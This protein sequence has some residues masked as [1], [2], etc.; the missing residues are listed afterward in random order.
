[1]TGTR[2]PQQEDSI[3][4]MLSDS[5]LESAAELRS[6]LEQLRAAVPGE[7]PAPRADLAALLAAGAPSAAR[8]VPAGTAALPTIGTAVLPTVGE[9]LPTV[10]A[11]P[12]G[13][14]EDAADE[15]LPA[16]VTSLAE[17]RGRKRRLAIVGG[18][19]VGAMTLGAGAV[20]ASSEDFRHSVS[21]TVGVIFHP[22]GEGR[23]A[24]PV[25]A[26]PSPADLP[27]A[28]VPSHAA[29]TP[30]PSTAGT[31]P[32]TPGSAA[33]VHAEP[34]DRATPPATGRGGILPTPPHRPVTPHMP[35]LPGR[36]GGK[37]LPENPLPEPTLPSMLPSLPDH[38]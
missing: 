36:D 20:A 30:T 31:A 11:A 3:Q 13:P 7:A 26:T 34:G 2:D 8:R 38:S 18:A 16:G 33:A 19:V 1:M 35:A 29:G 25:P 4:A 17:R 21:H 28:P 5:G 24:H 9:A 10:G 22:S 14:A 6:A 12:G 37:D 15:F 32:A 23:E 27:A